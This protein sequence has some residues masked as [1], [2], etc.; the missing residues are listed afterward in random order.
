MRQR[1]WPYACERR[2]STWPTEVL[3]AHSHRD[4]PRR[5]CQWQL[6]KTQSHLISVPSATH[7]AL[8]QVTDTVMS[9]RAGERVEEKGGKSYGRG[10]KGT[11]MTTLSTHIHQTGDGVFDQSIRV[12]HATC[13]V[14][15]P[16]L[17][18]LLAA[19]RGTIFQGHGHGGWERQASKQKGYHD[20][21][22]SRKSLEGHAEVMSKGSGG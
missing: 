19:V 12:M 5:W 1:S 15:T 17:T 14:P 16:K 18:G 22:V 4:R 7:S 6:P 3:S 8:L 13:P 21:R 10:N 9:T 11:C 20:Y 2:R